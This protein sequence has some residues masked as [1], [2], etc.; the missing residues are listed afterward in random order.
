M[1]SCMLPCHV[2]HPH[3]TFPCRG[4]LASTIYVLSTFRHF[5]TLTCSWKNG[6]HVRC[7]PTLYASSTHIA[8]ASIAS[9]RQKRTTLSNIE[10]DLDIYYVHVRL[11]ECTSTSH[12]E[13]TRHPALR[14]SSLIFI[15]ER[16]LSPAVLFHDIISTVA[17]TCATL[18]PS[19]C[20]A[21]CLLLLYV[22]LQRRTFA[23]TLAHLSQLNT[24]SLQ[25]VLAAQEDAATKR[26]RIDAA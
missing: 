15:V 12:S 11:S 9:S 5:T 4:V 17:C 19:T 26:R 13:V 1:V 8:T 3:P 7:P 14:L 23:P 6:L 10:S 25:A 22:L 20:H 18:R 24:L 16:F 2:L 21:V